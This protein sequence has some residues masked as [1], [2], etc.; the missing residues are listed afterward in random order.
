VHGAWKTSPL[1]RPMSADADV[2]NLFA[3]YSEVLHGAC[4]WPSSSKTLT[5]L[6]CLSPH[7]A[8]NIGLSSLKFFCWAHK[9]GL[10]LQQ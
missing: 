2:D 1:R 4:Y 5:A 10:F 6:F 8:D 9:F 3:T 7:P